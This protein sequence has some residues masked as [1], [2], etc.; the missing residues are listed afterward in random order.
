MRVDQLRCADGL[1]QLRCSHRSA[2]F[3]LLPSQAAHTQRAV[4]ASTWKVPTWLRSA[5]TG[6]VVLAGAGSTSPVAAAR[7]SATSTVIS[8]AAAITGK[9]IGR[10]SAR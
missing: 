9:P 7:A 2:V 3:Q 1:L 6:T 4:I 5:V 10:R 8:C